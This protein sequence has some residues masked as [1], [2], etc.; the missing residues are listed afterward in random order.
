MKKM[1]FFLLF[2]GCMLQLAAQTR[3]IKGRVTEESSG[4]PL[5]GVSVVEKGTT[6]GTKTDDQ[7]NFTLTLKAGSKT[8]QLVLSYIGYRSETL[9]A[10]GSAPLT[11]KLVKE[12]KEHEKL[13]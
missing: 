6:T 1:L 5:S 13:N 3:Q 10:D 11:V 2:T 12:T 8:S 7:G 4:N 9:T